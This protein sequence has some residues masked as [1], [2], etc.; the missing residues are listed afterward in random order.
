LAAVVGGTLFDIWRPSAPYILTGC[1]SGLLCLMAVYVLRER[2]RGC[3]AG[4]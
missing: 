3:R 1:L 2:D 4:D